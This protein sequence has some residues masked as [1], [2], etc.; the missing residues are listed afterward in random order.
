MPSHIV[1]SSIYTDGQKK[2]NM[3][4]FRYIAQKEIKVTAVKIANMPDKQK[5]INSNNP[6][7]LLKVLVMVSSCSSCL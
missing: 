3:L 4:N 5:S 6:D 7:A 2:R 1:F